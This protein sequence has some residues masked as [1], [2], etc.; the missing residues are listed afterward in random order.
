MFLQY[1]S[2]L[3]PPKNQTVQILQMTSKDISFPLLHSTIRVKIW[4]WRHKS[5]E[6]I[7]VA[8]DGTT[9]MVFWVFV[10]W[11]ITTT[12]SFN[13]DQTKLH[14][15]WFLNHLLW[16]KSLSG[17]SVSDNEAMFC[18]N[19]KQSARFEP[20]RNRSIRYFTPFVQV[21]CE[22]LQENGD[23][24]RLMWKYETVVDEE[25]IRKMLNLWIF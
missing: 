23:M 4:I 7:N 6:L 20:Q 2:S 24:P 25:N 22:I 16:L 8:G 19:P 3:I 11:C 13:T 18:L 10:R 21:R 9:G 17:F 5:E 15:P 1:N 14:I 12:H